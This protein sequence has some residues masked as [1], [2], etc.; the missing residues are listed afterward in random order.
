V[1]SVARKGGTFIPIT[2]TTFQ[3]GDRLVIAVLTT[4]RSRIESLLAIV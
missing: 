3:S 4:A 1:T 2:G